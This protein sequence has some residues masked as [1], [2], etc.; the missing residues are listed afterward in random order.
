MSRGRIF[1][2]GSPD[3]TIGVEVELFILNKDTLDLHPGAQT[4]IQEF[5]GDIH[6][7]EEL[8][9]SIVEVNTGICDN[10][11]EVREDLRGR[12]K[13]VIEI[14]NN[15]DWKILS[16]G[17]HPRA[18]WMDQKVTDKDRYLQLVEKIQWPAR[19]LLITGDRK[20]VV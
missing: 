19:R 18:K 1:F 6:V 3:P 10:I 5:D 15:H 9:E 4:I 8:L 14:A 12:I 2:Q 13:K 11:S 17:M 16:M 20:S 7:K